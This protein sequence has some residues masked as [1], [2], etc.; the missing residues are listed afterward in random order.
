MVTF[1]KINLYYMNDTTSIIPRVSVKAVFR[2]GD[3]VLYSKNSKGIR[4]IPGG[5][6]EFG[7]NTIDALKR[8]LKEELGFKL[9]K[10]PH[11]LHVW[12]Y[13]NRDKTAH[14]VYIVYVVDVPKKVRFHF[15]DNQGGTKLFWLHKSAIRAQKFLPEMGRYL[16]M[17]VGK[18]F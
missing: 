7:E 3:Y 8:E 12:T 6:V 5:H 10:K 1:S 9:K 13:I 16:L 18:S 4:D 2:C 14:R 11:L 17:A 15:K